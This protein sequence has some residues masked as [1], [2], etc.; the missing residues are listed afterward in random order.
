MILTVVTFIRLISQA[1]FTF[2]TAFK[3]ETVKSDEMFKDVMN[4]YRLS[5]EWMQTFMYNDYLFILAFTALFYLSIKVIVYSDKVKKRSFLGI[6]SVIPGFFSALQN[7]LALEIVN[8]SGLGNHF[9][10]YVITVWIKWIVFIPF[11]ILCLI[12]LRLQIKRLLGKTA[13]VTKDDKLT[14]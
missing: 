4:T 1:R 11:I 8:H 2:A 12:A 7:L 14:P 13:A 6:F 9:S 5:D 3:L 10:A